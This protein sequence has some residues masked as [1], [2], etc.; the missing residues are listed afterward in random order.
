MCFRGWKQ[1]GWKVWL[2]VCLLGY[3]IYKNNIVDV[4]T[5]QHSDKRFGWLRPNYAQP[6]QQELRDTPNIYE[7]RRNL[8]CSMCITYTRVCW[9]YLWRGKIWTRLMPTCKQASSLPLACKQTH[10]KQQEELRQV[11]PTPQWDLLNFS[12][13]FYWPVRS[14]GDVQCVCARM[15]VFIQYLCL[16]MCRSEL[17]TSVLPILVFIFLSKCLCGCLAGPDSLCFW[18]AVK[19]M[20]R[21]EPVTSYNQFIRARWRAREQAGH[22]MILAG[23]WVYF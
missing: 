2:Q 18:W 22:M 16:H 19:A 8:P 14:V 12:L 15:Y 3:V 21:G 20:L 7:H 23:C 5:R 10:T 1:R 6:W 17:Y 13:C 9:I 4:S 11:E